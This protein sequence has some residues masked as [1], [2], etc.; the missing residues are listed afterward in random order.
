M[1][2]SLAACGVQTAITKKKPSR[3][4]F[5]PVG[6]PVMVFINGTFGQF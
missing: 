5:V 1:F 2:P 6:D 4:F 3:F